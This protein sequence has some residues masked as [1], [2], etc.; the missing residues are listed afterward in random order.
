MKTLQCFIHLFR[1]YQQLLHQWHQGRKP[2][3]APVNKRTVPM[4]NITDLL[5][6]IHRFLF[7]AGALR[8]DASQALMSCLFPRCVALEARLGSARPSNHRSLTEGTWGCLVWDIWANSEGSQCDLTLA[9]GSQRGL[10]VILFVAI[11]R[12][13]VLRCLC[14]SRCHRVKKRRVCESI[15]G[16]LL[17]IHV[18][19]TAADS[20]SLTGGAT[21]WRSFISMNLLNHSFI[22]SFT[23]HHMVYLTGLSF[24]NISPVKTKCQLF[25][26]S[27]FSFSSFCL[28]KTW[29]DTNAVNNTNN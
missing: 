29:N 14:E 9:A 25:H 1:F 20:T 12:N 28:W 7:P 11:H 13:I 5:S 26:T 3:A 6:F 10:A 22:R 17:F 15:K 27:S 8:S 21:H 23:R 19:F 18:T 4:E 16:C 24:F 2:H